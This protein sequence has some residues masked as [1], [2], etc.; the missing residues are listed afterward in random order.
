MDVGS[1]LEDLQGLSSSLRDSEYFKDLQGE[2]P[3]SQAAA[4]KDT[5]AFPEN[6]TQQTDN[7]QE[8]VNTNSQTKNQPTALTTDFLQV[9]ATSFP[10]LEQFADEPP[11]DS[12]TQLS[13]KPL[14][15]CVT[16]GDDFAASALS[17]NWTVNLNGLLES[18]ETV[19][20]VEELDDIKDQGK[21]ELDGEPDMDS[22][23]ILVRSMSTSR[24]HSWGVPLSPLNSGR[25]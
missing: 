4:S 9:N 5:S 2:S 11:S 15:G 8:P 22:F 3:A 10:S 21:M 7:L 18:L 17:L 19:K 1:S 25:R 13:P 12:V 20:A 14:S 16:D 6:N 24:R 23:P